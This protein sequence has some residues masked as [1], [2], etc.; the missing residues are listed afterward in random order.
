LGWIGLERKITVTV[1]F[2]FRGGIQSI[3][4]LN[5]SST[6]AKLKDAVPKLC[7]SYDDNDDT[8][9]NKNSQHF[10]P[11]FSPVTGAGSAFTTSVVSFFSSAM[12]EI[13][14]VSVSALKIQGTGRKML[15][16]VV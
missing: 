13:G 11:C 7:K 4:F 12:L 6:T 10:P 2:C 3:V 8:P 16:F 9:Q 1:S 5:P 14:W 15:S